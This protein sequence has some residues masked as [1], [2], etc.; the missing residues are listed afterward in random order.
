[1]K[2]EKYLTY[3]CSVL[4]NKLLPFKTF[5]QIFWKIFYWTNHEDKVTTT[6][7]DKFRN[8]EIIAAKFR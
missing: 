2:L 7:V 3:L 5:C 4:N 1:M 8:F 6:V